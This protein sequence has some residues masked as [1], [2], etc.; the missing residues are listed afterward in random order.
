MSPATRPPA[1]RDAVRLLLVDAASGAIHDGELAE[2]LDAL[3]PGD[4]VV[5]FPG[6][7]HVALYIGNGL[8][9]QAPR[10]G[11]VVKI[12]PIASNP[13]RSQCT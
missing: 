3:R 2:L 11:G 5:Y 1:T 13:A 8:V 6:A 4:L 12:S 9:I 7:T 10:P